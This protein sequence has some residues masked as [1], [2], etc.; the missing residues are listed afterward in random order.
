MYYDKELIDEVVSRNDIVD[1]ISSYIGLKRAGTSYKCCCPFHPEKTPSFS[2]SRER[3]IYK[4]FGCGAGGSALTFVMKYDNMSYV[5]AIQYLAQRVGMDLPE[6]ELSADEKNRISR[7]E[8]L[9][10]INL[11]ATKYFH[12]V[13]LN[14]ENGKKGYEYFKKRGYTDETINKF[15]LG[16]ADIYRDD[17]YKRAS[18]KP[19]VIAAMIYLAKMKDPIKGFEKMIE[20]HV[21]RKT[22]L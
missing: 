20:D 9:F 21:E 14:T 22:D 12:Y 4:C 7:R 3:Q 15:G 19:Y 18:Y 8:K 2:V 16:F 5:E 13:L 10:E 1:V 6:R 11:E 17:L